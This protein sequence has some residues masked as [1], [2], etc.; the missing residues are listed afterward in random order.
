[1]TKKTFTQQEIEILRS[2]IYTLRVSEQQIAF[3]YDFKVQ[4]AKLLEQGVSFRKIL[5]DLGYDPE[6]L[7]TAR[8]Y[9]ISKRLH[10]EMRSP[11]GIHETR[12]KSREQILEEL[13]AK[14]LSDK[15]QKAAIKE[16]QRQVLLLGQE[17]E[18]LKKISLLE[19]Q[20]YYRQ[21]NDTGKSK[22]N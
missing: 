17:V 21:K 20:A 3:T 18:F 8:M 1:M 12:G 4:A 9:M 2:N 7:G 13:A 19:E 5:I 15:K 10:K 14:D 16:L 22:N 6:I 11:E